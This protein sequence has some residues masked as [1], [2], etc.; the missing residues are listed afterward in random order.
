MLIPRQAEV[1][2]E[3]PLRTLAYLVDGPGYL[4]WRRPR[5]WQHPKPAGVRHG[6]CQSRRDRAAH[7]CED[8]GCLDADE[9][10]QGCPHGCVRV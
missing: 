6:G 5:D 10:T 3:W 4:P 9:V 8:D 2:A 1:D 7:R